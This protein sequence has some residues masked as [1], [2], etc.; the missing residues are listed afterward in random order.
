[1]DMIVTVSFLI[2]LHVNSMSDIDDNECLNGSSGCAH[3]CHDT[4]GSFYCSCNDG[5]TLG[6]NGKSCTGKPT[7]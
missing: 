3:V 4:V 5:Y 2:A 1:M 7:N 6:S